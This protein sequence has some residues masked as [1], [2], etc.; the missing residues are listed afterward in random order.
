ML[1][2]PE[3]S[4]YSDMLIGEYRYVDT[5]NGLIVNTLSNL[6]LNLDP[7]KNNIVGEYIKD[8]NKPMPERRVQ[9]DFT[10]PERSYLNRYII[11]KHFAAQ[12]SNPERIEIEFRGETSVVPDENSPTEL[13]VPEQNY[14]LVKVP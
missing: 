8:A 11:I 14:T 5:N 10:D 2:I 1:Y 12:G 7:Y 3:T 4:S 9:L 6:Q 13:R